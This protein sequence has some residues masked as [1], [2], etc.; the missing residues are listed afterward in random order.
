MTNPSKIE[1]VQPKRAIDLREGLRSAIRVWLVQ[2]DQVLWCL[3]SGV[4]GES[5]LD[6][7]DLSEAQP[8]LDRMNQ[9]CEMAH[10]FAVQIDLKHADAV[11]RA[12]LD[13]LLAVESP[14]FLL[15]VEGTP[16]AF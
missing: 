2:R 13:S 10:A 3:V 15:R 1:Q 5:G 8:L 14:K 12:E 4:D 9:T 11:L 16:E 6:R 7:M